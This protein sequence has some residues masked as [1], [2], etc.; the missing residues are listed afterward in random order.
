MNIVRKR[1]LEALGKCPIKKN[2]LVGS[3]LFGAPD[4]L[5]WGLD[6]NRNANIMNGNGMCVQQEEFN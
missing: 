2:P 3:G 5:H 1:H 4:A 6:N